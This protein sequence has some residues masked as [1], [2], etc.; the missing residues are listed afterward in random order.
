MNPV[1]MEIWTYFLGNTGQ[2]VEDKVEIEWK[3]NRNDQ[4]D[5]HSEALEAR[6]DCQGSDI[7]GI[8][9]RSALNNF[10][11]ACSSFQ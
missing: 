1:E 6:I 2:K 10:S 9:R 8:R 4:A 11:R 5:Y 7:C 3:K